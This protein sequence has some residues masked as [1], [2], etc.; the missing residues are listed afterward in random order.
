MNDTAPAAESQ[1]SADEP[2]KKVRPWEKAKEL[3]ERLTQAYP[4]AFRPLGERISPLKL[5]VHKELAP[6]VQ[7]WGYDQQVLKCAMSLY[8][9]H[10]RYQT[11]LAKAAHRIDLNGEAAEEI[12]EEHR[13][14]AREQV[15]VIQEKRR[16]SRKT[17]EGEGVPGAGKRADQ[18]T[19]GGD[20]IDRS[21][22]P[23]R[24]R[25]PRRENRTG[26]VPRRPAVQ[27][28][29]PRNRPKTSTVGTPAEQRQENRL[30]VHRELNEDT[31]A[32]LQ[33]KLSSKART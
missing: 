11:A 20:T 15:N 7:Q 4:A 16:Q 26:P 3:L 32:A 21:E 29:A 5:G 23:R 33:E 18:Q 1:H 22:R 2:Q 13:E 30:S 6:V 24:S 27:R 25:L 31:I 28:S 8:T 9:R 12:S 17:R 10:L 19:T 14:K